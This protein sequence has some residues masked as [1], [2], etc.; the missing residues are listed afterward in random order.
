MQWNQ[1][2]FNPNLTSDFH[3]AV[4]GLGSSVPYFDFVQAFGTHYASA[5]TMGGNSFYYSTF[6]STSYN[7]LQQGGVDMTASG[8]DRCFP[9]QCASV[10]SLC[11]HDPN[12]VALACC[13]PLFKYGSI[14]TLACL[15]V[16]ASLDFFVHVGADV[17]SSQHYKDY[18][19]YSSS[20]MSSTAHGI[21]YPAPPC[22]GTMCSDTTAWFTAVQSL[23]GSGAGPAPIE[24]TLVDIY[25]LLTPTFF[26]ND[27]NIATKQAGLTKFLNEEY[28]SM[29]P[30]C[31]VPVAPSPSSSP[32][33]APSPSPP[34]IWPQRGF[35]AQH[36]GVSPFNGPKGPVKQVWKYTTDSGIAS[37]PILG[38]DGTVYI[39]SN[40]GNVYAL[41]G[42][43]GALLWKYPTGA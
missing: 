17:S 21:P 5:L 38:P 14:V 42:D 7:S 11:G 24:M 9:C 26:P 39:G 22:G 27:A 3:A 25:Q 28:C 10:L 23:D 16:A 29:V 43:T 33:P 18:Q 20:K 2:A 15:I 8:G 35:N 36:S 19:A 34:A 4:A 6:N 30:G 37:S 1:F 13:F 40:D 31:G 41:N 32:S 12:L